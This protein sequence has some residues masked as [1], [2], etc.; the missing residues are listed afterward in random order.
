MPISQMTAE[1]DLRELSVLLGL[2]FEPQDWGIINAVEA[3][4]EEFMEC[5]EKHPLSPSARIGLAE[6]VL[7][8]ANDRLLVG[9]VIDVEAILRLCEREPDA[10]SCYL[11]YW[12]SLGPAEE[13]PIG[14]TLR[15]ALGWEE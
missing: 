12:A 9:G 8:S 4:L 13:F 6:L 7:A 14:P 5:F 1:M 11:S 3:R 2:P 10:F 15:H